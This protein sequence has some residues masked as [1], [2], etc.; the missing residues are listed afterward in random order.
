MMMALRG[1]YLE[2][3]PRERWLLGAMLAIALPLLLWALVYRPMVDGLEAAKQ[4]HVAAVQRHALLLGQLAQLRDGVQLVQGASGA[5][6]TLVAGESAMRA[7]LALS[8]NTAQGP[9]AASVAVAAAPAPAALAWLQQLEGR[10]IRV[11]EL[12]ITPQPGGMV[13]VSAQLARSGR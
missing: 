6:V 10:G 2:R 11:R 9:D 7:G 4:R 13:V 8:G 3:S 12:S 5:D 1:W